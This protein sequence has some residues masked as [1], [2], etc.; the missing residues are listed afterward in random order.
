M[1]VTSIAPIPESHSAEELVDSC[2][3]LIIFNE[4][5]RTGNYYRLTSLSQPCRSIKRQH[6]STTDLSV[7][8]LCV[9]C[10]VVLSVCSVLPLADS[11]NFGQC[12]NVLAPPSIRSFPFTEPWRLFPITILF[13]SPNLFL[14]LTPY[15]SV[16]P[17]TFQRL[18]WIEYS[19]CCV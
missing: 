5:Q 11:F 7:I 1:A 13:L 16:W 12:N 15:P 19:Y 10:I 4:S 9:D 8:C 18:P 2:W 3:V 14:F 17:S 6:L